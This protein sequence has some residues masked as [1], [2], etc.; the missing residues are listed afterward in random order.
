MLFPDIK[1][2][3]EAQMKKMEEVMLA[4][5]ND[6]MINFYTDDCRVLPASAPMLVGKEGKF[7]NC[8][9]ENSFPPF[10][11]EAFLARMFTSASKA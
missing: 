5:K 6:E 9:V 3:I 8:F 7:L 11:N 2:E 1:A 4:K 10:L